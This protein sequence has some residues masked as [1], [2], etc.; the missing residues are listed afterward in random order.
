M[1]QHTAL[2]GEL[3]KVLK[4]TGRTYADV[5]ASLGMSEPSVKRMFASGQFSL[6]R[7]DRICQFAGVEIG[8]L[9]ERLERGRAL[10]TELTEEQEQALMAD[11]KLFLMTYLLLNRWTLED[12]HRVYEFSEAELDDLLQRLDE[13]KIVDMR[14]GRRVR[15]LLARSFSWRRNGPVQ[16]YIER[17]ILPEFFRSRFDEPGAEFR[18]FAA[19]LTPESLHQIR[20]ALMEV[21]KVFNRAAEEDA[22]KPIGERPGAAAV[23]AIR[24][25]HFSRF[26]QFKRKEYR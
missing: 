2:V 25:W 8:D 20:E 14:L 5:A 4:E 19:S 26:S 3:K 24:P 10:I 1:T 9:I 16:G 6:D 12:I 13:L 7:F 11:P 17:V 23:L 21:V 15:Y 18:F 22:R